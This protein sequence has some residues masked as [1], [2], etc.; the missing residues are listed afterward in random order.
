MSANN[1]V[2]LNVGGKVFT[3]TRETLV[4]EMDSFLAQMLDGRS[5][6]VRDENWF[7]FIDHDPDTF[8]AV[9][10][11]LR[12]GRVFRTSGN[13]AGGD[14]DRMSDAAMFCLSDSWVV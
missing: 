6:A 1:I 12:S 9:L 5:P 2:I 13:G 7:Y 14:P 10:E 3:T 8:S 11:F 4:S